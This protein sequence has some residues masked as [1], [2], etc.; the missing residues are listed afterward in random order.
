VKV[1]SEK[2]RVKSEKRKIVLL[3]PSGGK[4]VSVDKG[5]SKGKGVIMK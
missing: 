5:V 4:E 3:P 1:K 2:W